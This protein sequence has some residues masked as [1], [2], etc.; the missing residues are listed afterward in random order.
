MKN[1]IARVIVASL[2]FV[3][4]VILLLLVMFF[5][6]RVGLRAWLVNV[7]FR[8]RMF[9]ALDEM[10]GGGRGK[11]VHDFCFICSFVRG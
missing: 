1:S 5:M 4:F 7:N 3:T 8:H 2:T 9:Y 11:A 10:G 6:G